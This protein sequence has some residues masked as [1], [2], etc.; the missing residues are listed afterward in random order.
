[1]TESKLHVES[2]NLTYNDGVVQDFF[3]AALAAYGFEHGLHDLVAYGHA[4]TTAQHKNE[5][6]DIS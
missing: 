5:S 2:C 3:F 4:S 6:N 1:M